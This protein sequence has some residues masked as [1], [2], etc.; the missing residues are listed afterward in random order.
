MGKDWDDVL[1]YQTPKVVKIRERKL[2]CM[3]ITLMVIIIFYILIFTVFFQ[4]KHLKVGGIN[5]VFRLTLQHPTKNMCNPFHMACKHNFTKL[6]ELPY[7]SQSDK[8]G[9]LVKRE[10]QYWDML[11][12]VRPSDQGMF[13]PTRVETFHQKRA[14]EPS[15][16]NNWE[17]SG[18]LYQ[19]VNKDGEV[20]SGEGAA[21]PHSDVFMAEPERFT[22]LVDHSF[23]GSKGVSRDDF[24]MNGY[25]LDCPAVEPGQA[26]DRSACKANPVYCVHNNCPDGAPKMGQEKESLLEFASAVVDKS[27]A[28]SRRD[29][30]VTGQASELE[31]ERSLST[32]RILA[33]ENQPAVA[34]KKGDV[35]SLKH[36][37]EIAHYDDFDGAGGFKEG[38]V[39]SRGTVLVISIEYTNVQKWMGLMV[40]PWNPFGP[41]P[42]YHYR[43][44]KR[45][46]YDYMVRDTSDDPAKSTRKVREWHGIRVVVEQNANIAVWDT[47]QLILTLTTALG[48]LAV[49]NAI[50]DFLAISVFKRGKEYAD[51]KYEVTEDFNP[52][53]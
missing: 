10:C 44:T 9:A 45:P 18:Y 40:N 28:F 39:R 13:I 23:R 30:F 19:F 26:E 34:V 6:Q 24:S 41:R 32:A 29:S 50:T 25:W 48:L 3:K 27:V 35:F 5:G 36:L 12:L 22:L 43:V 17:C 42:W 46:V 53:D 21:E 7:C 11:D 33:S 38:S 51:C 16:A 37:M 1:A 52:D 49:S 2:G 4:G 14:C 31:Q 8:E 15:A 47:A 20:A